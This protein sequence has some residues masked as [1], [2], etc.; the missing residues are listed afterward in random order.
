MGAI[1]TTK[2]MK[3]L[4][5]ESF[6]LCSIYTHV[7]TILC[8]VFIF[9][10]NHHVVVNGGW[11]SWESRPCSKS[12][13]GGTQTLTRRCSTCGRSNCPGSNINEITCNNQC[14]PGKNI[15]IM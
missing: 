3:I 12:C 8:S 10:C 2:S 5:F 1:K 9:E 7:N 14:C 15:N 4:V 6:R 13:G 11:S